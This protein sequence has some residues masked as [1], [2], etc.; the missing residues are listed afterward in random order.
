MIQ[1][2]LDRHADGSCAGAGTASGEHVVRS[3]RPSYAGRSSIRKMGAS[4]ATRA[5]MARCR[6]R[7]DAGAGQPATE[8]VPC[9]TTVKREGQHPRRRGGPDRAEAH[10]SMRCCCWWRWARS[11]G[12]PCT[13]CSR[14]RPSKAT[15]M[16]LGMPMAIDT[17]S[18]GAADRLSSQHPCSGLECPRA[19]I[20]PARGAIGARLIAVKSPQPDG[21]RLDSWS[22][23]LPRHGS[24]PWTPMKRSQ[25]WLTDAGLVLVSATPV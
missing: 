22:F 14:P 6:P 16:M 11:R 2:P 12:R 20:T 15:A 17:A 7:P 10:S 24:G 8:A 21:R 25:R 19:R 9:L 5:A 4:A 23:L 13:G 1:S 3:R 18:S